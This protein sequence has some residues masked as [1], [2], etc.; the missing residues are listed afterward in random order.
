M[1]L[2]TLTGCLSSLSNLNYSQWAAYRRLQSP[3]CS[4]RKHF[5][6]RD[7]ADPS[8]LGSSDVLVSN[9]TTIRL[10]EFISKPVGVTDLVILMLA[11]S[12]MMYL[13]VDIHDHTKLMR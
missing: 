11:E 10:S 4:S 8:D 2:R 3:W 1:P 9:V 5:E 6:Q 13:Q 7:R 12:G